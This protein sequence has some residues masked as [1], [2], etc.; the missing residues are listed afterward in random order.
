MCGA[1]R[2]WQ[3]QDRV[4]FRKNAVTVERLERVLD[5]FQRYGVEGVQELTVDGRR[6]SRSYA[7]QLVTR[8]RGYSQ[9]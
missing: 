1:P 2:G 7:Y 8:A 6:L 5:L 3:R 4:A 9:S